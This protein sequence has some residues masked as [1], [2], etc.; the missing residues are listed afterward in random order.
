MLII[1]MTNYQQAAVD[2]YDRADFF[3]FYP[4]DV[5]AIIE[6]AALTEGEMPAYAIREVE[7]ALRTAKAVESRYSRDIEVGEAALSQ[8]DRRRLAVAR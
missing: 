7:W 8:A 2:A 6:R 5:R 1:I 3:A 4:D